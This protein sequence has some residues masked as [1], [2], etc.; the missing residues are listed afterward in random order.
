MHAKACGR[1]RDNFQKHHELTLTLLE[2][3]AQSMHVHACI[4]TGTADLVHTLEGPEPPGGVGTGSC[5]VH[6][7]VPL[8][9]YPMGDSRKDTGGGPA[10]AKVAGRQ[11]AH[12][13]A[14]RT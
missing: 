11:R 9:H 14:H 8:L 13:V 5:T 1:S 3:E 2:T 10:G 4:I 6:D 7:P 12:G